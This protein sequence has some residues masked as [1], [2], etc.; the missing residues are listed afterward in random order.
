MENTITNLTTNF[1]TDN[2]MD[3]I[4]STTTAVLN[5]TNLSLL[6]LH[7][8]NNAAPADLGPLRVDYQAANIRPVHDQ[9]EAVEHTKIQLRPSDRDTS[10]LLYDWNPACTHIQPTELITTVSALLTE[11]QRPHILQ[12]KLNNYN[13]S[14]QFD[15][16]DGFRFFASICQLHHAHDVVILELPHTMLLV[17]ARELLH[18]TPVTLLT[19]PV[20]PTSSGGQSAQSVTFIGNQVNGQAEQTT[21]APRDIISISSTTSTNS[22]TTIHSVSHTNND[23]TY[24]SNTS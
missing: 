8:L 18:P 17:R 11:T 15:A 3:P 22:R 24:N 2:N 10:A 9:L 5:T 1:I 23:R 7:N 12:F 20:T 13:N 6:D 19:S 21:I 14:T 16:V 4:T